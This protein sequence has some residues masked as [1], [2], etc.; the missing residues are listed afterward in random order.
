MRASSQFITG[1]SMWSLSA[2]MI[3]VNAPPTMT[4]TAISITLPR[5]INC[6]NSPKKPLSPPFFSAISFTSLEF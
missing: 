5:V 4:P 6:L 3:A 2:V 1:L